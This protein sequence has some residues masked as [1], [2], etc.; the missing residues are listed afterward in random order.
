[1]LSKRVNDS[2]VFG[3]F[4]YQGSVPEG[5]CKS[6]LS[7]ISTSL[8]LPFDHIKF[9]SLSLYSSSQLVTTNK[10]LN[11]TSTCTDFNAVGLILQNLIGGINADVTCGGNMWRTFLCDGSVS[12]CVNCV[13]TCAT[14]ST[15]SLCQRQSS[16]LLPPILNPCFMAKCRSNKNLESASILMANYKTVVLYPQFSSPLQVTPITNV[17]SLLVST[18]LSQSGYLFC[19]SFSMNSLPQSTVDIQVQG[20]GAQISADYKSVNN[21]F[22]AAVVIRG[23][24]PSTSYRIVCTTEDFLDH[25]MPL[26][27]ALSSLTTSMTSCCKQVVSESSPANITLTTSSSN[28]IIQPQ[29]SFSLNFV[30]QQSLL[31]SISLGKLEFCSQQNSTSPSTDLGISPTSAVIP[32]LSVST[33]FNV[34]VFGSASSSG[35]YVLQ[36]S[37]N[38]GNVIPL[39]ARFFVNVPPPS[40]LSQPNVPKLQSAVMNDDGTYF[41]VNFDSATNQASGVGQPP[42]STFKCDS[43]FSFTA[44]PSCVCVWVSN[45]AV[46]VRFPP[47]SALVNVGDAITLRSGKIQALCVSVPV[48]LCSQY[49]YAATATVKI[50][51]PKNPVQ[52][53]ADI[54]SASTVSICAGLSL[55]PTGSVGAGGRNWQTVKWNVTSSSSGAAKVAQYLNTYYRDTTM[56]VAVPSEFLNSSTTYY[57]SLYLRNFL[58]QSSTATVSVFVQSALSTSTLSARLYGSSSLTYRWKSVTFFAS[59]VLT[60]CDGVEQN[61]TSLQYT[62]TLY[63][64]LTPVT[65]ISSTSI[66]TRFFEIAP[67]SLASSTMYTL[68]VVVSMQGGNSPISASDSVSF[69]VGASGIRAI[70]S[71]GVAQKANTF[72][73]I[74]LDASSSFD[75]DYPQNFNLFYTWQCV[76]YSP[77]S[78]YGALCNLKSTDLYEAKLSLAPFLLSTGVYNIS[79]IVTNSNKKSGQASVILTISNNSIPLVQIAETISVKYNYAQN[80]VLTGNI[81][82]TEPSVNIEWISPN[83]NSSMLSQM[84]LT[85]LKATK[86]LGTST[87]QL[88]IAANSLTLGVSYV[89]QLK[90]SYAFSSYLGIAQVQVNCNFPPTSGRVSVKPRSGV[91]LDTSFF[92]LTS[93]WTDDSSDLPLAY[94]LGYYTLSPAD[95]NVLK[96][97]DQVTYVTS[98]LGQGL[99]SQGY[100]VT[101]VC[102]ATDIFGAHANT[103]STVVVL[104]ATVS[105]STISLVE[106]GIAAALTQRNPDIVNQLIAAA[107]GSLN[108]VDCS[109]IPYS[110]SS[111]NRQV[112]ASTKNTCGPCLPGFIGP[113]G[114]SNVACLPAAKAGGT[115]ASCSSNSTCVSGFCAF[116]LN[117]SRSGVCVETSKSCPNKCGQNGN[118]RYYDQNGVEL[119]SC[120][121]YSAGCSASCVCK[122][123]FFGSA[124]ALTKTQLSQA[125]SYR[126]SLCVGLYQSSFIQQV[127]ADTITSRSSTVQNILTDMDQVTAAALSNCAAAVVNSVFNNPTLL[128]QSPSQT[129]KIMLALSNIVQVK[130]IILP[131]LL[132]N[133]VNAAIATVS[134]SCLGAMAVGQTPLVLTTNNIRTVSSLLDTTNPASSACLSAQTDIEKFGNAP[135]TG[136]CPNLTA[137]R[138]S[139]MAAIGLSMVSYTNN[140]ARHPSNASNLIFRDTAYAW[141][142]SSSRRRLSAISSMPQSL[143]SSNAVAGSSSS[144]ELTIVVQN[145]REIK[146]ATASYTNI[147][148]QCTRLST[149][150]YYSSGLCPSGVIYNATCPAMKRGSVVASCPS[151]STQPACTIW[152]GSQYSLAKNCK[153]AAYN[154]SSTTCKCRSAPAAETNS[155]E[156]EISSTVIQSNVGGTEKFNEYATASVESHDSVIVS[157]VSVIAA[158]MLAVVIGL[159]W[160]ESEYGAANKSSLKYLDKS[161]LTKRTVSSFF[162][163]LLPTELTTPDHFTL[164]FR[165]IALEHPLCR[166]YNLFSVGLSKE[167]NSSFVLDDTAWYLHGIVMM[168]KCMLM[169]LL[170]T[171]LIAFTYSD[172]GTCENI[173]HVSKDCVNYSPLPAFFQVNPCG[174]DASNEYCY[175]EQPKLSILNILNFSIVVVALCIPLHKLLALLSREIRPLWQSSSRSVIPF[176]NNLKH[177]HSRYDEFVDCQSFRSTLLRAAGLV[178]A[179]RHIDSCDPSKEVADIHNLA[180]KDLKRQQVNSQTENYVDRSSFKKICHGFQRIDDKFILRKVSYARRRAAMVLQELSE[181][182]YSSND[183]EKYLM[184]QF[185]LESCSWHERVFL[186]RYFQRCIEPRNSRSNYSRILGICSAVLL[187]AIFAAI[188]YVLL[189]LVGNIGSRSTTLW[190]IVL[191]CSIGADLLLIQFLT[192]WVHW[193]VVLQS[194]SPRL[195]QYLER[196]RQRSRVMLLRCSGVVRSYSWLI[197]RLNPIC[198]AVRMSKPLRSLPLSRLLMSC[199]DF[200]L[201]FDHGN[202][203]DQSSNVLSVAYS[204]LRFA[205]LFVVAVLPSDVADIYIES[206]SMLVV[207]LGMYLAHWLVGISPFLLLV[208]A[209]LLLALSYLYFYG[210]QQSREQTIR[211]KATRD[212]SF[213]LKSAKVYAGVGLSVDDSSDSQPASSRRFKGGSIFSSLTDYEE[214]NSD[215]KLSAYYDP[216]SPPKKF[217]ST[218][219]S[220][221]ESKDFDLQSE[222][223]GEDNISGSNEHDVGRSEDKEDKDVTISEHTR[224]VV[225]PSISEEEIIFTTKSPSAHSVIDRLD[226]QSVVA[227]DRVAKKL[228]AEFELK[229]GGDSCA[230]DEPSTVENTPARRPRVESQQS[231]SAFSQITSESI[232]ADNAQHYK[233]HRSAVSASPFPLMADVD[234]SE[235]M[236]RTRLFTATNAISIPAHKPM[237]KYLP[238]NSTGALIIDKLIDDDL[239]LF[240]AISQRPSVNPLSSIMQ[241]MMNSNLSLRVDDFES[242][243]S[244]DIL[245]AK[246]GAKGAPAREPSTTTAAPELPPSQL[247]I[248]SLGLVKMDGTPFIAP[249]TNAVASMSMG[250]SV[251][252]SPERK[253]SNLQ[254]TRVISKQKPAAERLAESAKQRKEKNIPLPSRVIKFKHRR[255][256]GRVRQ[257]ETLKDMIDVP[258][259]PAKEE[260]DGGRAGPG[261]ARSAS[262]DTRLKFR[263]ASFPSSAV[264]DLKADVDGTTTSFPP[265]EL[266]EEEEKDGVGRQVTVAVH[267]RS[268]GPGSENALLGNKSVKNGPGSTIHNYK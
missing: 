135:F 62:W 258:L 12:L 268:G 177:G 248:S 85:K 182:S 134:Q 233:E 110:C 245:P 28:A 31:L 246:A 212:N 75:I 99:Y 222:L 33:I 88:A 236:T 254:R 116:R 17:N 79:V 153:V 119:P 27:E 186:Q 50:L 55:D 34:L 86:G 133:N 35:C 147:S 108:S 211:E 221:Q 74:T 10:V 125:Q 23:L 226:N 7:F 9:Y 49:A 192:V 65:G 3:S 137:D 40:A 203:A 25:V 6:W 168:G 76:V 225:P 91:S 111:I 247:R 127:T 102:I 217:A 100:N 196:L 131:S 71:G 205:G 162:D 219:L 124:C 45:S 155:T 180:L 194:A 185:L 220:L 227:K 176:I 98:F 141:S 170:V 78:N 146:Y 1:M 218:F 68:R 26:S 206:I 19:G 255:Y 89:F 149:K 156:I 48:T 30:P 152:S 228:D 69:S 253:L 251:P 249:N 235:M 174:W 58:L 104:P 262:T 171:V 103:T 181:E 165:R 244:I 106:N 18:Y 64:G 143:A 187:M 129:Q 266:L 37:T 67:Y 229:L 94:T 80:I 214:K 54:S 51:P 96:G 166:L 178:L 234:R 208:Y 123:G 39:A 259:P 201:I 59:T 82:S 112:C 198:R 38:D 243:P 47:S 260:G 242:Q 232:E 8:Q 120:S 117:P 157:T 160:V 128:C 14:S 118:C 115:G 210:R 200:D 256:S 29:F 73:A 237:R 61:S 20:F 172:D 95:L 121:I 90:A 164:F 150:P 144:I 224:P 223:S 241:Q 230:F 101:C 183:K 107:V 84:S 195:N 240:G 197:Q 56:L 114:D 72:D 105:P 132:Y 250:P 142:S 140:P 53:I 16:T 158:V 193:I 126:E 263:K 77:S 213:A 264:A 60:S 21:T 83:F 138:D 148:I 122:R 5:S 161:F 22:A 130:N 44:S 199:N 175:F 42:L 97:A 13:K 179:Q 207:Y 36:I 52:P 169:I 43:I 70:I 4:F 191:F 190:L 261:S 231:E 24:N 202:D 57:V 151:Y 204:W 15:S 63:F 87:F 239:D 257:R 184:R 81:L 159:L 145:A 139:S 215:S 167:S 66:D 46:T 265:L 11:Q 173:H 238:K 93:Y 188:V 163:S 92:I 267:S 209:V 41:N 216:V 154:S 109:A 113:S 2:Q 252:S 189:N 32:A 136:L